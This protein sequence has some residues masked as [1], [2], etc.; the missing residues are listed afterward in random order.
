I[1]TDLFFPRL[2]RYFGSKTLTILGLLFYTIGGCL[3][4]AFDDIY[5]LLG[6]RA[7][8]GI[9]VGIIMPLST[10]LL[11]FYFP[12]QDQE[13][14]MGYSS[15]MNQ[16]GGAVAT[17]LSGLLAAIS[18]RASFLVYAL[19]LICFV[20]CLLFLPNE[21]IPQHSAENKSRPLRENY[22]YIVAIFL[23]MLTFFIYPASFAM[24][25]KA[26]GII[27][28]HF[29]AVI[30]AFMDL[31]ALAGGLLFVRFK[32]LLGRKIRFLAPVLFFCGYL[33][34][35]FVG[36]WFGALL[37]S[38][39]VGLA[40]GAG[41]PFIISAASI[42]AGKTAATTVMPLLS[43]AL[44]SAQ[45]ITPIFLGA[46]TL[47]CGDITHLPY[48]AAIALGGLFILWSHNLGVDEAA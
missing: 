22:R 44:Y 32:L 23:L 21:R 17:L 25:I 36:G 28:Q 5:L 18:W 30:M 47:I 29:I 2:C 40:N 1:I 8:V 9:G 48:Y 27:P 19:G 33:L 41:I 31:V 3:A 20:L 39:M 6:A 34:L 7:L 11:S 46:L 43:A 42:K 12:P 10:G 16:L 14:L 15:A 24:E 38:F 4:G 37:G 35:A 13:R 45:F 26:E